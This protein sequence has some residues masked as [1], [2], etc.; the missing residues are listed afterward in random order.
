MNFPGVVAVALLITLLVGFDIW[1]VG[2]RC[3]FTPVTNANILWAS[4]SLQLLCPIVLGFGYR[5][6][7]KDADKKSQTWIWI[8]SILLAT[9]GAVGFRQ[10]VLYS[11]II[12][13]PNGSHSVGMQ[14]SST[15]R[16]P[17]AGPEATGANA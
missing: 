17:E 6:A 15:W 3:P 12:G 11:D 14:C 1:T 13:Q 9:A 7:G 4:I 16:Q 10:A 2:G 8:A 5:V